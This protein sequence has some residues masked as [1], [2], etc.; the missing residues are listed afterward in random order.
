MLLCYFKQLIIYKTP[1]K[2][3]IMKKSLKHLFLGFVIASG[4]LFSCQKEFKEEA[5]N[6]NFLSKANPNKEHGHLKQTKT[7]SSEVIQKWITLQLDLLRV[8]LAA[9]ATSAPSER[10]AGYCGIVAYESVVPGMPDYQSLTNQLTDF[11]VMPGTEP[12]KAYHWPSSANAALAEINRKLFPGSSAQNKE[13]INNLEK[14]IEMSYASEVDKTTLDRSIQFGKEVASRVAAWAATDGSANINPPYIPPVGPG[15]W[16]PTAS[17]PA[18]NPYSSQRR[19]MVPGVSKNTE[20][21]PPPTYSTTPGSSFWEMVK[22]VYDKSLVLTDEQKNLAIYHRDAPGYPGGGHF[23]ALL[24]QVIAI[25]QPTLDMAALSYAKMGI[26]QH[27]A[28]LICFNNKYNILLVRP[29]TYIRNVMGYTS[30][31]T[32]IPTP[33]HPEFPSG[34]ATINASVMAMLAD[35]YGTNFQ[36]TLH[37]YDYLNLT[38]PRAYNSFEEM[39]IDM[40]NSRVYGGIH[41]QATCDKSRVQGKQV[42]TNILSTIK[43]LK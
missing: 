20:L 34:H 24:G 19:L 11:P 15:L 26:G 14:S 2:Y 6:E 9:G 8:P 27:D 25:A 3:H 38:P 22:D 40:A 31:N 23:I 4:L 36:M 35:V 41:Y 33:N 7:H 5:V 43:F 28:T 10:A 1:K 18:V 17:T 16:V 29:V 32:F 42:A 39:S 13:A 30:W 12:G 37:T 21:E